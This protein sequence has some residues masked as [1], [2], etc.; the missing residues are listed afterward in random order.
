M[1]AST[2]V[3]I[4]AE[5]GTIWIEVANRTQA[6]T[7]DSERYRQIGYAI[8]LCVGDDSTEHCA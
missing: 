2:R 4:E 8:S 6:N 1:T 3:T 5:P 7:V